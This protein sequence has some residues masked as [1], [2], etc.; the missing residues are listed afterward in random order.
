MDPQFSQIMSTSIV[1]LAI[2]VIIFLITLVLVVKRLIGFFI[3]LLLLFFAIAAGYAILNHD[4]VREYLIS[5]SKP[6]KNESTIQQMQRKV[7]EALEELRED[8][9]AQK[10]KLDEYLHTPSAEPAVKPTVPA[11]KPVDTVKTV[12]APEHK[13]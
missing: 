7:T 2:S 8:L 1:A 5:H 10:A 6:V 13:P 12:P 3:T 9:N 11:S 4:I